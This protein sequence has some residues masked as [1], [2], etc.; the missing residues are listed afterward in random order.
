MLIPG[1]SCTSSKSPSRFVD[2]APKRAVKAYGC[3]LLAEDG[4]EY[5]D[6]GMGLGAC[7]LGYAHT[8]VDEAAK[9]AIDDGV[10]ATLP[11]TAEERTAEALLRHIP[12]AEQARFAKDGTDVTTAAVRLAR[13]VTGRD[14]ILSH[15]YHGWADWSVATTPPAY[16]IPYTVQRNTQ[17]LEWHGN[18]FNEVVGSPSDEWPAAV[19]VEVASDAK[20][21]D[22]GW[23]A[24]LR[25]DCDV[26]GTL[27]IFDEILSGFRY[28]MG[29]ASDVVPDLACFG[30][31]I[32]NGFPLSALVGKRELM[33]HFEPGGVFFSGTAF[34]ETTSLAA[35]QAT[36]NVMERERVQDHLTDKGRQLRDGFNDAAKKTG[37]P[38]G[39]IGDGART[40]VTGLNKEQNDVFQ[41]E[42]A[43]R[44]LLY[45]G[46]QIMSLAHTD[47]E[48]EAALEIYKYAM[49][50]MSEGATLEGQP[51]VRPYRVQA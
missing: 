3:T 44:G 5:L 27:L 40:V 33:C 45:T 46:S 49:R 7:V 34:G 35:C 9:R 17:R 12:W 18:V 26:V 31:A 32:A 48:V 38:G 21:D 36:L 22:R 24:Q 23:L 19:I 20:L 1:G 43:K 28:R 15:G 47:Y 51:T 4:H 30:K 25:R 13:Y 42:C 50:A 8:E 41:Q 39:C 29:S 6:F 16:G 10:L 37:F 2:A 14:V 11:Y